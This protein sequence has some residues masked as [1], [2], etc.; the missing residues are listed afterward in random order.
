MGYLK[1]ITAILIWS[2]LGIFIRS[3][4]DSTIR[5][6][7]YPSVVAGFLQLVILLMSGESKRSL[8]VLRPG[9][10]LFILMLMPFFS[11]ANTFLFF[12]AYKHTTITHAVFTHYTAPIFVAV[13]APIFLKERTHRDIWIAIMVSSIGLMLT[14]STIRTGWGGLLK[15]DEFTG[16]IAGILSGISYAFLILIIRRISQT[17]SPLF[18]IFIQNAVISI[19]LLPFVVNSHPL[20][21]MPYMVI[22]GVIH[23]TLA[24]LLYIDGLK[25]V[26]ANEAAV[27][28]YLEP[29]GAIVLAMIFLKEVPDLKALIGGVLI[30]YS[31]LIV[32]KGRYGKIDTLKT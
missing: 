9:M 16:V 29:V 27:L 20:Q 4:E 19:V 24:P 2:S 8:E 10:P 22:M 18:I 31:G 5:I 30:V 14:V 1:V 11:L 32:I 12:F 13:M 15:N 21:I 25:T 26:K 7:F 17:F 3:V 28:G 6:I 23:S